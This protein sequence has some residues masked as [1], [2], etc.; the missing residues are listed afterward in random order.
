MK[1]RQVGYV[2]MAMIALGIIALIVRVVS[3]SPDELVLSGLLPIT[4]DVVDGVTIRSA[5]GLR[6]AKLVR[7]GES[8]IWT[9]NNRPVFQPKLN[10]FW[11]VVA[12]FDG[13]QLVA[14]NPDNHRRMGVA[15]G[16]G[17]VLTFLIGDFEQEKFLIG[18][19]S[20]E[21]G[22]CYL[23]RPEKTQ[24]HAIECPGP[25]SQV[26]DTDPEGWRDPVVMAIPRDEIK[27]V[28]FTYVDDEFVMKIEGGE[29]IVTSGDDQEFADLFQVERLMQ[30]IESLLA[31]GFADD[32]TARGLPFES[33]DAVVRVVTGEGARNP[34]TRLRF[35]ERDDGSYYVRTGARTTVYILSEGVAAQLLISKSELVEDGG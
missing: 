27:S 6:E 35:L 15:D 20:I 9:I 12:D 31:I 25:A 19:W 14:N 8:Q 28:T 30:A 7:P 16:Q 24:V 4:T 26:F 33:P 1:S 29:V 23:R 11:S 10:I 3:S 5:D 2:L 21:T 17:T 22:L 32:E 34:A 18:N 13:A